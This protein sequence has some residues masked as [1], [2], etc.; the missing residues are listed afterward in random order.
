MFQ[1]PRA[2]RLVVGG[3]LLTGSRRATACFSI[4]VRIDLLLGLIFNVRQAPVACFSILVR[5]DL[6]LGIPHA[7]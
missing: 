4:L 1:Y 7:G 6:L 3:R 2:D 5:I